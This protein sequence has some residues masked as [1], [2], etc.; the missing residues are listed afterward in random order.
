V[1][2]ADLARDV[3]AVAAEPPIYVWLLGA[4]MGLFLMVLGWLQ[5]VMSSRVTEVEKLA[6]TTARELAR[7][8][9]RTVQLVQTV[10]RIEAKLDRVLSNLPPR[11]RS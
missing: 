11:T 8:D 5:A 1:V 4:L 10:E 3:L 9:E 7:T 2:T 6:S